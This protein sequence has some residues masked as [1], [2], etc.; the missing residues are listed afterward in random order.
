MI[1]Q[2]SVAGFTVGVL[3]GLGLAVSQMVNPEKV[4]AFLNV[5]A[6][7]DPSLLLVMGAASGVTFIGYRWATNK[8]PFFESQ[9]YLPTARDIDYRLVLGAVIFGLGWGLAG[10]CPGPAITGLSSGASE[11]FI[12]VAAMLAGSQIA[13]LIPVRQ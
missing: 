1:V 4:L 3:F 8:A 6:N 5:V 11:P 10:Y 7:W 12:F 13:R 9:H 2:R